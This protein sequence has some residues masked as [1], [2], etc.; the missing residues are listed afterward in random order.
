[1]IE[2]GDLVTHL[3]LSVNQ[4]VFGY[5]RLQGIVL[6]VARKPLGESSLGTEPQAQVFW[7]NNSAA[8]DI[9]EWFLSSSL[10]KLS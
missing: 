3:T 8:I 2:T 9:D 5:P 4:E 10:T 7:Y 6:N 1:M